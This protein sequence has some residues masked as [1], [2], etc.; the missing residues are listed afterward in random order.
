MLTDA[1]VTMGGGVETKTFHIRDGL[2]LRLLQSEGGVLVGWISARPSEATTMRAKDLKVDFLH[3]SSAPKVQAAEAILQE[4][5]LQWEEIAYMGDDVVDLGL[6]KRAGLAVAPADAIEEAR[7]MADFVT[8]RP[9]GQGAVRELTDLILKA[10][11]RWM[12]MIE[13]FSS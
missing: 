10:Q 1:K 4:R 6:L 9:G 3:Q 5:G 7:A 13:K 8:M 11:G 2:G 12:A